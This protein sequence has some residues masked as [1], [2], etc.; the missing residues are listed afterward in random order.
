MIKPQKLPKVDPRLR[1]P[2]QI[3]QPEVDEWLRGKGI[4]D[5]I[6]DLYYDPSLSPQCLPEL[7]ELLELPYSLQT[8]EVVAAAIFHRKPDVP[9]KR[10]AFDVFLG[11][12][13][14]RVGQYD[15]ILST[16][17]LNELARFV[18]PDRMDEIAEMTF[19]QRYGA[20]RAE[21]AYLLSQTGNPG[22]VPHLIRAAKDPVTASL[23]LHGLAKLGAKET[24]ALCEQALTNPDVPHKYGIRS[25]YSKLKRQ[26]SK[27]R[28]GPSHATSDPP[29]ENLEEWSVNLDSPNVTKVLR[30][31][32]QSV[33]AGFGRAEI[34]EIRSVADGLSMDQ[35]ACLKFPATFSGKETDIW[36]EIFCDDE[37][38]L[39]LYVFG[40]AELIN[41]IENAMEKILERLEK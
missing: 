3:D 31:I 26:A 7:L 32:Q 12:V 27:K 23:A 4:Q 19:D 38:A 1:S 16:L 20:L 41:R 30:G 11:I 33:E 6:E 15:V 5:G 13:K 39:D 24:L 35:T 37:D 22:A 14:Q 36:L 2:F 40:E 34:S 21:L 8:R 9:R 18:T 29:P 28:Q 17:V 25:I 10:R